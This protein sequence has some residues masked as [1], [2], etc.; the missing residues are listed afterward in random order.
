MKK[1]SLLLL[2]CLL[3]FSLVGCGNTEESDTVVSTQNTETPLPPIV[4]VTDNLAMLQEMNS[5]VYLNGNILDMELLWKGDIDDIN[6][7]FVAFGI[8][9]PDSDNADCYIRTL[10]NFE[11]NTNG[12]VG[13]LNLDI[14]PT[15]SQKIIV[16]C[17]CF[18]SE[19]NV[20]SP[21]GIKVTRD[22][23]YS[24]LEEGDAIELCVITKENDNWEVTNSWY[25]NGKT[26][27]L[28]GVIRSYGFN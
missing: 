10:A 24:V 23:T 21:V 14:L 11:E 1:L 17:Q 8:S 20:Q 12:Y 18:Y 3:I 26:L 19:P 5:P 27:D 22:N 4:T 9:N 28:D 2:S 25:S 13:H 6:L 7:E 16:W 15:T